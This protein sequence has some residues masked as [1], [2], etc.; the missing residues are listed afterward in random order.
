MGMGAVKTLA[1]LS[2]SSLTSAQQPGIADLK[3]VLGVHDLCG[4]QPI[5]GGIK[6]GNCRIPAM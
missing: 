1:K 6:P 5:F 3:W 4:C 2:V